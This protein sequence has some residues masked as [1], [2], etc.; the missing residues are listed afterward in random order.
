M[1]VSAVQPVA[2]LRAVFWIAWSFSVLV[3]EGMGDQRPD[4]AGIFECSKNYIIFPFNLG[5]DKETLSLYMF[6]CRWR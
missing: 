4:G 5:F 2:I 1:F 6:F 3:V